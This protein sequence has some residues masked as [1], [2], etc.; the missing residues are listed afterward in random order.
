MAGGG[1]YALRQIESALLADLATVTTANGYTVTLATVRPE[2]AAR[3]TLPLPAVVVRASAGEVAPAT[4]RI[5]TIVSTW[6][7][8]LYLRSEEPGDAL[9]LCIDVL[10][11][12]QD[13]ASALRNANLGAVENV[14][15]RLF[16]TGEDISGENHRATVEVAV[17]HYWRRGAA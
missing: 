4:G 10:N 8:E 7:L 12:L 17:R 6:E 16:R 11:A 1:A 14:A 13:P 5:D 2:P 9:D 15:W 3:S